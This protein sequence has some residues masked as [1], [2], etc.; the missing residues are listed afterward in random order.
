LSELITQ[1]PLAFKLETTQGTLV[2][3]SD[4]ITMITN[5]T[6]EQRENYW[7]KRSLQTLQIAIKEPAYINAATFTLQTALTLSGMLFQ[8]SETLWTPLTGQDSS[9]SS[10][11]IF[12]NSIPRAPNREEDRGERL[13]RVWKRM[14][15]TVVLITRMSTVPLVP[16]RKRRRLA[17]DTVEGAIRNHIAQLSVALDRDAIMKILMT[18]LESS[19]DRSVAKYKKNPKKAAGKERRG[20]P[21]NSKL[22][23]IG[24]WIRELGVTPFAQS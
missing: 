2:T 4:A 7:W 22:V 23:E 16:M 11:E 15:K 10:V 18:K 1:R 6:P 13:L 20:V 17:N 3:L 12:S 14:K 21:K 5:M 8:S 24:D 9:R 19:P